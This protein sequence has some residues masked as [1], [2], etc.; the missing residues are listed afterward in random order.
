LHEFLDGNYFV[1][2]ASGESGIDSWIWTFRDRVL[3][4]GSVSIDGSDPDSKW[5]MEWGVSLAH[6]EEACC[7]L[8]CFNQEIVLWPRCR[9]CGTPDIEGGSRD[10]SEKRFIQDRRALCSGCDVVTEV[11]EVIGKTPDRLELFVSMFESFDTSDWSRVISEWGAEAVGRLSEAMVS[12][13]LL[14]AQRAAEVP[15]SKY[16]SVASL[17]KFLALPE[18]VHEVR[19]DDEDSVEAF[20]RKLLREGRFPV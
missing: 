17:V 8:D 13:S 10:F 16:V 7:I 19:W 2:Y 20:R 9:K 18:E 4:V 14:E 12:P 1:D 6:V 15:R 3:E 5:E 11:S